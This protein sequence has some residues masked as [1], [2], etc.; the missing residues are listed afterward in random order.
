VGLNSKPRNQ[1]AVVSVHKVRPLNERE[2]K[3]ILK[4][5]STLVIFP[6]CAANVDQEFIPPGQTVNQHYCREFLQSLY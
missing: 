2:N 4:T 1:T 5:K 6:D 3:V